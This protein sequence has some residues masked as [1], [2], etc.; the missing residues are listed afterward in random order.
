MGAPVLGRFAWGF[1]N[2]RIAL[3]RA[4]LVVMAGDY[5]IGQQ[6]RLMI[7]DNLKLCNAATVNLFA[8]KMSWNHGTGDVAMPLSGVAAGSSL[9][10][11]LPL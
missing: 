4:V 8:R 5:R 2:T 10:A 3:R 6:C 1:A 7:S 9:A 11:Y